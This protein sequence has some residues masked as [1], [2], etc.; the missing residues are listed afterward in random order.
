MLSRLFEE[1]DRGLAG[2]GDNGTGDLLSSRAD[3]D[4]YRAIPSAGYKHGMPEAE[5]TDIGKGDIA[6]ETAGE[7]FFAYSP[8]HLRTSP[9]YQ[10][11]ARVANA[12]QRAMNSGNY[13]GA[14]WLE[15]SP[16]VEDTVYWLNLLI[17]TTAPIVANAAQRPNRSLSADG[18]H[19]IV[20]AVDY[21]VSDIWRGA[22][23]KDELGAVMIQE[24]QIFAA[25][26]VQKSDARPG[27][28]IATGDHGG[29]LG[30]MGE[31]GRARVY[32]KPETKHTWQSELRLTSLPDAVDGVSLRDGT[33]MAVRVRVKDGEGF[34][35]G[36]S[37]P[38]VTIVKPAYFSQET[39]TPGPDDEVDIL[40][41]IE[42]NLQRHPLAGFVAE[43]LSPY[44]LAPAR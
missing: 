8:P 17:D 11:L 23:G 40:A 19:N 27:G 4:F 9:R 33:P 26:Q 44:H 20:D 43:G 41:R 34:L 29:I 15:G 42:R 3:Y 35:L 18:P 10:D 5:R 32:F 37:I 6:P 39:S 1:I 12:V 14:I 2:L 13:R 22:D 7:D 38:A 36:Q 21:I 24:E 25:R 30:T 28:Y 31:P 16:T